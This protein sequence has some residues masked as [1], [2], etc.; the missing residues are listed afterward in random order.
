MSLAELR[1]LIEVTKK[2]EDLIERY[3]HEHFGI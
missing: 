3:W 2:N 1:E